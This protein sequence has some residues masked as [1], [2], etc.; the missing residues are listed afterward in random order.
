[1]EKR[2]QQLLDG[3]VKPLGRRDQS[4]RAAT[5]GFGE[6]LGSTEYKTKQPVGRPARPKIAANPLKQKR[7]ITSPASAES[8]DDPIDFLSSQ[9]RTPSG[10]GTSTPAITSTSKKPAQTPR[11]PPFS[12]TNSNGV[13]PQPR[14]AARPR[15]ASSASRHRKIIESDESEDSSSSRPVARSEAPASSAPP[16]SSRSSV[17]SEDAPA[18]PTRRPT[19]VPAP[20]P[21]AGLIRSRPKPE[22]PPKL[23][24]SVPK[25]AP[26]P[27]KGPGTSS[28]PKRTASTS[29][30]DQ[31]GVTNIQPPPATDEVANPVALKDLPR[32]PKK[33]QAPAP[34]SVKEPPPTAPKRVPAE[35]PM[36]AYA[37][38][39]AAK[40]A[41]MEA[42][43]PSPRK[44]FRPEE[45]ERLLQSPSKMDESMN[46]G[47]DT[48]LNVDPEDLCP[49]CD[50]RLPDNPSPDLLRTMAELKLL[51]KPEPR[52]RNPLGMKAPLTTFINLCHMHRAESTHVQRGKEN[53]WPAVID[54][55]NVRER[56][57]S[58]RVVEALQEIISNP[59]SSEFFITLSTTIKRDGALKAASIKA[60]LNNFELSHPGYYGEQGSLIFFDIL[61]ELFPDF[62]PDKC[63]P[64][65][66]RE[67]FLS[68]LVP[69]AAALLVEEDM[70][71]SHE[72]A[73]VTLRE[74]RQYGQMMFPDRGDHHLGLEDSDRMDEAGAKQLQWR[75]EVVQSGT[76]P[77]SVGGLG[78]S[79]EPR[80]A[81]P[82]PFKKTFSADVL[83]LD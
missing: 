61:T 80:K 26:P 81:K 77:I 4:K 42:R 72:E 41:A 22:E 59:E 44:R 6:H 78:S 16:R 67:F 43:P 13:A 28:K 56:L 66:P 24:S 48:L 40:A 33:G 47:D 65:Q 79:N 50:E 69:E 46:I 3:E 52:A 1:M 23:T 5:S 57:R 45:I 35:F 18:K 58:M 38:E 32:I 51:A 76:V 73:L 82:P 29:L 49:F 39:A 53:N 31:P 8:E 75:K 27:F 11:P 62:S 60:Q 55:N 15:P 19:V 71:C 25:P 54:W 64:L 20:A 36:A 21:F 17:E 37:R 14:A 70:S 63:K 10:S 9:E 68:V 30:F 34:I 12:K 74:S 2:R 7:A 83:V